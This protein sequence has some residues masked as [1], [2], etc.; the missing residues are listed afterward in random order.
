M[1]SLGIVERVGLAAEER[2]TEIEAQAILMGKRVDG[3]YD[4]DPQLNPNAVF[5]PDLTYMQVLERDLKVMDATAIALCKN[6]GIPIHVFNLMNE[7]NIQRVVEGAQ[8]GTV[9]HEGGQ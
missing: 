7:G 4:D 6:H 3:V 9:V 5:L 8:I 1:R 2:L